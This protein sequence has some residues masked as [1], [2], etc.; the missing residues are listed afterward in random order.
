MFPIR[1]SGEKEKIPTPVRQ[2]AQYRAFGFRQ[3]LKQNRPSKPYEKS[4]KEK[5][6]ALLEQRF[7]QRND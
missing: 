3:S 7:H 5:N 4:T 2:R 1:P 6:A